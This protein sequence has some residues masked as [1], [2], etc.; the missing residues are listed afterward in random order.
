MRSD[1][2]PDATVNMTLEELRKGEL[3]LDASTLDAMIA[4][5]FTII[6]DDS[7]VSGAFAF[8]EPI[9]RMRERGA[10]VREL[11]FDMVNVRV[12]G[13]SA[14]AT[15][16]YRKTWKDQGNVHHQEG[17][18]SDVFEHR[19]DGAWILVLRHRAQL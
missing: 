1:S 2:V 3:V 8:L 17:W 11:R 19:D 6:E 7:R 10:V 5:S 4:A 16:R 12:F 15:Y 13:G 18:A 9:R 14:V